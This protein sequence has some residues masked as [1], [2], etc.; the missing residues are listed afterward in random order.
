MGNTAAG[1]AG[2]P[3]A[4]GFVAASAADDSAADAGQNILQAMAVIA[5]VV[6]TSSAAPTEM[7]KMTRQSGKQ[8]NNN[9]NGQHV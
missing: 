5:K 1:D 3:R 4:V 6:A 7:P 9:T 2:T 8:E